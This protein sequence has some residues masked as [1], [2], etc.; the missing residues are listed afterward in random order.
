MIEKMAEA[1]KYA[2]CQELTEQDIVSWLN[3]LKHVGLVVVPVEPTEEMYRVVYQDGITSRGVSQNDAG[4][5][6]SAMISK[7]QE[8]DK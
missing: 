1:F 8:Q 7:Y 4:E 6:Y 3:E 5:I 2:M